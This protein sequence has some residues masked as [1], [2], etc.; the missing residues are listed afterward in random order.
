MDEWQFLPPSWDSTSEA[1]QRHRVPDT[2][3]STAGAPEQMSTRW[4][5]PAVQPDWD[6]LVSSLQSAQTRPPSTDS[7]AADFFYDG[8]GFPSAPPSSIPDDDGCTSSPPSVSVEIRP[9]DS[10][11][12]T[13]DDP[14]SEMFPVEPDVDLANE[15]PDMDMHLGWEWKP[16]GVKWLDPEVS[17]EVV[18]FPDGAQLTEKQKIYALHRVKGCPSQFP[19]YRTRTAFLGDLTDVQNLD[20]EMTV[21]NIIRDQDS[22]SWGGSCG[23][24][25]HVDAHL[26]GSFFRLSDDVKI[27]CRLAT[28]KCGGVSACESLDSAF[29]SEERRFITR[30]SV[31]FMFETRNATRHKFWVLY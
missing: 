10:A 7:S 29:L 28:P 6:N 18:E 27:A 14:S 21:D 5:D 15:A 16:S 25:N 12:W 26:P 2:S 17:S 11:G 22:H 9:W 8:Y 24:R 19:F 1:G 30:S 13:S 31:S 4:D 20:P 3:A 23:A